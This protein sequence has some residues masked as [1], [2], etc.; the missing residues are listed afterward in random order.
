MLWPTM[1]ALWLAN[2]GTPPLN[3]MLIF[4]GGVFTMRA[5]GC[6]VNDY[7]D[8]NF[9]GDVRRTQMRP[10]ATGEITPAEA[11]WVAGF[12]LILAFALWLMLGNAARLWSIPA[13]VVAASYPYLKRFFAFPQAYL[14]I[15]FSFG[16]PIAYAETLGHV[17]GQT[18]VIFIANC[19]W[20][21]AYDTIY[22]IIDRD[23]DKRLAVKSSAITLGNR[24]V[25]FIFF[26]YFAMITIL[27]I[28]G[29][30]M[31]LGVPFQLSLLV[32]MGFVMLLYRM[33]RKRS[34]ELCFQAF[35]R[36][37]WLGFVI[38]IGI[39]ADFSL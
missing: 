27:S 31:D 33:V 28:A 11:L 6:A 23:D 30:F 18:W 38:L 22:A 25:F 1:W 35:L 21:M 16:I 29:V 9:D 24:D 37:H 10:L 8:R 15:A 36:N 12:F 19:F 3:L 14:G 34:R 2:K 7:A 5:F 13:L 4:I 26:M 20:V 17:P 32:C 39:A